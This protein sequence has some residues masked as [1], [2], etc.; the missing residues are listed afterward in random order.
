MTF[1]SFAAFLLLSL[2]FSEFLVYLNLK[3]VGGGSL[4]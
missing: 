1:N 4:E 3:D 2:N